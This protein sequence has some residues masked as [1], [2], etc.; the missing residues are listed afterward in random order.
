M[1]IA[2]R[3]CFVL[4]VALAIS[5]CSAGVDGFHQRVQ[6]ESTPA[7]ASVS[8]GWLDD[9]RQEMPPQGCATPCSLRLLRGPTYRATFTRQGCSSVEQHLGAIHNERIFVPLFPD[10]WT[11]Q[12]YDFTPNPVAAHLVCTAGT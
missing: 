6:F 4:L 5:G 11:G 9:E 8:V 2:H 1:N 7:G 10:S 3:H 12:T